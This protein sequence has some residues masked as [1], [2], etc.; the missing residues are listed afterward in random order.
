[1]ALGADDGE[2]NLRMRAIDIGL[3]HR[4]RPATVLMRGA[5]FVGIMDR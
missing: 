1:V 4:P 2:A 5:P 3:R